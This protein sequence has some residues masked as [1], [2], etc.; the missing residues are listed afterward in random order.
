MLEEE[1]HWVKGAREQS[2]GKSK[3]E[4]WAKGLTTGMREAR[5]HGYRMDM[6]SKELQEE[7][8]GSKTF[9]P[10]R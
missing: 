7:K 5:V 10:V 4:I 6:E 8:V 2:N 9:G 3:Q 1:V